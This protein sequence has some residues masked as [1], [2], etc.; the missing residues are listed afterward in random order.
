VGV[1]DRA[2]LETFYSTGIRRK[3][4]ASLSI[5]DLDAARATLM[6]REGKHRKE[7]VL[8]IGQRAQVW[9][10]KY[11]T[12]VRPEIAME[13]DEGFL[14]LTVDGLPFRLLKLLSGIVHKCLE[15]AQ[16]GKKGGCH[17]FRHTMATS[18]LE[19]GADI[20]YIQ[21]M[22]GHANLET[23]SIYTHVSIGK[24][25]Q[26]HHATHPAEQA[27]RDAASERPQLDVGARQVLDDLA[28]QDD[29]DDDRED[30]V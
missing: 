21:E 25:Q 9:V 12:D 28:A 17:L 2:I 19:N 24:L 22:L 10:Q 26:I 15:A 16:I 1:R 20:R 6:V 5:Y 3:E 30:S 18:M 4:L 14:F 29:A 8:P 13:P 23:T 11:L 27:Y 7:R